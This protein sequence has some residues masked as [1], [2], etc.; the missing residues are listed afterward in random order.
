MFFVSYLRNHCPIPGHKYFLL[1][2]FVVLGFTFRSLIHFKLIVL[3]DAKYESRSTFLHMSIWLSQ[4]HLLK[5]LYFLLGL[6]VEN[7]LTTYFCTYF[8]ILCSVPLVYMPVHLLGPHCLDCSSFLVKSWNQS[9]SFPTLLFFL[10]K[11]SLFFT[12]TFLY[13]L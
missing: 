4:H 12:F 13:E 8:W 7:Q 1:K 5:I 9:V 6:S 11:V 2:S 3:Y 10:K